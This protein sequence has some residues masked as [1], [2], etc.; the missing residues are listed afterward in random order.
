MQNK[1]IEQGSPTRLVLA[2]SVLLHVLAIALLSFGDISPPILNKPEAQIVFKPN[3]KNRE[4]ELNKIDKKVVAVEPINREKPLN[5]RYLAQNDQAAEKE[6]QSSNPALNPEALSARNEVMGQA[7]SNEARAGVKPTHRS[8]EAKLSADPLGIMIKSG[9]SYRNAQPFSD[10][11]PDVAEG[12][13]TEINTWQWRHAEFFNRIK[14][15]IA[16]HW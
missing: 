16:K 5:A 11:L 12:D 10:Y 13:K 14:M 6:Q 9:N 4:N 8:L 3:R 15:S 1:D 2:F 7:L